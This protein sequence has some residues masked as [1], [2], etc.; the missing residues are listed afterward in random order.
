[1]RV[2]PGLKPSGEWRRRT[3]AWWDPPDDH[4]ALCGRPLAA[5]FF[6]ATVAGAEAR[7]CSPDCEVLYRL[8]RLPASR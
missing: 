3:M 2:D 6:A 8:R 5:R 4:C 1:V 7:F